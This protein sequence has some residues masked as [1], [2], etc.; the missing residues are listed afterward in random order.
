MRR[1]HPI[2]E[3]YMS[4]DW[5]IESSTICHELR[6][7]YNHTDDWYEKKRLR[8]AMGMAKSITN[9]LKRVKAGADVE[10]ECEQCGKC[11]RGFSVEV[12]PTKQ[13]LEENILLE[14]HDV[15]PD[16]PLLFSVSHD[17]KHLIENKCGIYDTRPEPCRSFMCEKTHLNTR[18]IKGRL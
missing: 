15:E 10:W 13:T 1:K 5:F 18:K 11:C 8:V 3:R 6:D 16:K 12:F 9:R 4:F 7:I 14:I 2:D 17:C